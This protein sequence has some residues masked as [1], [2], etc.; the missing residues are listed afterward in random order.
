MGDEFHPRET[1][2][3]S[4]TPA[5]P[6]DPRKSNPVQPKGASLLGGNDQPLSP[7]AVSAQGELFGRFAAGSTAP[8]HDH[9]K[10]LDDEA[11]A[12]VQA[13]LKKSRPL[14]PEKFLSP[15]MNQGHV[16]QLEGLF[17][18]GYYFKKDGTL[19]AGEGEVQVEYDPVKGF[20]EVAGRKPPEKVKEG[21]SKKEALEQLGG[22]RKEPGP[23][24]EPGAKDDRT[25]LDRWID[26]ASDVLKDL[27]KEA[28]DQKMPGMSAKLDPEALKESPAFAKAKSGDPP[29][30]DQAAL[31]FAR[32]EAVVDHML[33]GVKVDETTGKVGEGGLN[34]DTVR[35]QMKGT[36]PLD[37]LIAGLPFDQAKKH[38][39]N[40]APADKG[41]TYEA[42]ETNQVKTEVRARLLADL[43]KSLPEGQKPS[44]E[45]LEQLGADVD[46]QVQPHVRVPSPHS[47]D[48]N[49]LQ[50][51]A[52]RNL[53]GTDKAKDPA[54][55]AKESERLKEERDKGVRAEA[56]ARLKAKHGPD[57]T[58]AQIE[59][60]IEELKKERKA[61]LL[62]VPGQN[63]EDS[64]TLKELKSTGEG[65]NEHDARQAGVYLD[66]VVSGTPIGDP[67]RVPTD[68]A[69]KFA[70]P[71]G[72]KGSAKELAG[73]L[74]RGVGKFSFE[75]ADPKTGKSRPVKLEDFVKGDGSPMSRPEI[76][77]CI[78]SGNLPPP[79]EPEA[80]APGAAG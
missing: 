24:K 38:M 23:P 30:D 46:K 65:M 13:D 77:A 25:P 39:D 57:V 1:P 47:T 22:T 29:L 66:A 68:V 54:E 50:A 79:L 73:L 28:L 58:D 18:K 6:I 10:Y 55:L 36:I 75:L 15:D 49:D 14:T 12:K 42:W 63:G 43:Q 60:E 5:S 80:P 62:L 7:D 9:P 78:R 41:N 48:P 19:V 74:E 70:D 16:Q 56:L 27:P 8:V 26:T 67:P 34:E 40:L 17:A 4:N 59:K 52:E 64:V 35:G 69:I 72:A 53:A 20:V 21:T 3:A 61:D 2:Q 76:E 31:D 37:D 32:R 44:P 71:E 11:K 33:S 45:Q 51:Q